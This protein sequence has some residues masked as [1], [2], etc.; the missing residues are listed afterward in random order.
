[1]ASDTPSS[2]GTC[3]IEFG[4]VNSG[5]GVDNLGKDAQYG[6]DQRATLGYDEFIGPTRSNACA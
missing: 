3:T 2:G 4:N 5:A 6:T 1:M